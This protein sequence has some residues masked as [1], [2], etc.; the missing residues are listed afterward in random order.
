MKHT[1]TKFV[2]TVM[3]AVAMLP[4][5]ASAQTG[6]VTVADGT[7]SCSHLP[8]YGYWTDAAQHNQFIY[9]A[10]MLG[11]LISHN[12]I[13][14]TFYLSS[15][16]SSV[17]NNTITVR[18]AV[19]ADSVMG[20]SLIDL[21][22]LSGVTE[23]VSFTGNATGSTM[24][25]PFD[26]AFP[27]TGGN[28]L[29]D[30]QTTAA[31][32][33]SATFSGIT[34]TGA[35]IYSYSSTI[36]TTDELPKCTFGWT[37]GALCNAPS[38]LTASAPTTSS[39]TITWNSTGATEYA[40]TLNDSTSFTVSDTTYT[41][42]ELASNTVYNYSVRAIC[43]M[44]TS[45]A[46]FG[47]TRTSCGDFNAPYVNGFEDDPTYTT[48]NCW[49]VLFGEYYSYYS[50]YYPY[51]Y[52]WN[53][54]EGNQSLYFYSYQTDNY[55]VL[56]KIRLAANEMDVVFWAYY[57]SY[58]GGDLEAGVMTNP[59]DTSTF[60]PMLTVSAPSPQGVWNEYE[61][62]TDQLPGMTA[63]DTVYVAFRIKANNYSSYYYIDDLSV[64]QLTDCRRPMVDTLMAVSEDSIRF[65]W[66]NGGS[67]AQTYEVV[68]STVNDVNSA[69][70]IHLTD[71]TDTSLW[72]EGLQGNKRYYFWIRT[73]CEDTTGWRVCGYCNTPCAAEMP[74]PFVEDFESTDPS[75]SPL[76][77]STPIVYNDYSTIYPMV[78]DNGAYGNHLLFAGGDSYYGT[79]GYNMAVSPAIPLPANEIAISFVAT[80]YDNNEYGNYMAAGVMTDP[81]DTNTFIPM[82][83]VVGTG[84][85]DWVEYEFNTA[86]ITSIEADDT[87]YLAFYY[88]GNSNYSCY[89][90]IDNVTISQLSDCTRPAAAFDATDIT[91][92]GATLA[93]NSA[94][95]SS[96]EVAYSSVNDI[97]SDSVQTVTASDTTV[98]LTGLTAQTTYYAWVRTNCGGS[99]SDWR[100]F[101][102]F[103]T[104]C[105]EGG[106][107]LTINMTDG[108]GDGWNGSI[109]KFYQYDTVQIAS[110]TIDNGATGTASVM[111]CDES[112]ITMKMEVGFFVSEVGF[113]VTNTNHVV[114]YVVESGDLS[115]YSSGDIITLDTLTN[116]CGGCPSAT[117]IVLDSSDLT[118]I[119]ISWSG[120]AESYHLY[121]D[122]VYVGSTTDTSYTFTG[123][124]VAKAYTVGVTGI[125]ADGDSAMIATARFNTEC[126]P[127]YNVPWTADF[128]N[129]D[130]DLVPLCWNR[131]Y[132]YYSYSRY[133]YCSSYYT[134]T[135][136]LPALYFYTSGVN[137]K[138]LM[139]TPK[140]NCPANQLRITFDG[141][142]YGGSSYAP[143]EVGIM[144]DPNNDSTFVCIDTLT[145]YGN[146]YTY[147]I[148]S[149]MLTITDS[150]HVAFRM[151]DNATATYGYG[152]IANLRVEDAGTCRRALDLTTTYNEEEDNYTVSWV[153]TVAS[154][155]E[156]NYRLAGAAT[157]QTVMVTGSTSYT[158][159]GLNTSSTYEVSVRALCPSGDTSVAN[160]TTFK[161]RCDIIPLPYFT[162][163]NNDVATSYSNEGT[164]PNCWDYIYTGTSM[165]YAPKVT[166]GT[167]A[168][169]TWGDTTNFIWMVAGE[170][171]SYGNDVYVALPPM[172]DPINYL[173]M[174]FDYAFENTT[175]GSNLTVG[176]ATSDQF[177][178]TFVAVKTI[179]PADQNTLA[180]DTVVFDSVPDNATRIVF[181]WNYTTSWYSVAID[182]VNVTSSYVGCQAP[183]VTSNAATDNSITV[184]FTADSV[185]EV[186]ITDGVWNSETTGTV[187]SG[188]SYTFTGLTYNTAY[189]IGL[190][191]I[192]AEGVVSDWTLATVTT[193]DVPCMEPTA[194]AISNIDYHTATATWTA[195][196]EEANWEVNIF[197]TNINESYTT[198]S[199][200]YAFSNL[201]TGTQYSVSVRAL[202]GSDANIEGPWSDTVV[203][204]TDA[205][206]PVTGV[207][208]SNL[209]ATT[210][211]VSWTASSNS[212]SYRVEYGFRGMSQ[213]EGTSVTVNATS[214]TITGL[215]PE[216]EYDVYVQA[217][218]EGGE[219]SVWSDVSSFT[220]TAASG[221]IYTISAVPADPTMGSV[222]GGG[223]YEE[224]TQVTLTAVPNEG[225]HFVRWQDGNTDNPRVVTVTGNATYVATF[226]ANAGIEDI[227][228][229]GYVS[230]YPNPASSTVTV[231][232][233]GN[234]SEVVVTIVD[235]NGREV[236]RE[237]TSGSVLT[238]DIS[239][240][241]QG[242]Y[243]VRLTG[244]RVNA[245]R[246]LIVK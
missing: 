53:S 244:E 233:E 173:T 97:N 114:V 169:F 188:N 41:F 185:V 57:S 99:V 19:V 227:N 209:T 12:I 17:W 139:V 212:S 113:T 181:R 199:P 38:G 81:T 195:G 79:T 159:N 157:W 238:M 96:Y 23:V 154:E 115:G 32:Y 61:F 182:N 183:V 118:S 24:E 153:N 158:L 112:P 44:D 106:C 186:A 68:Y 142:F 204:T 245:I 95:G 149:D 132:S 126:Y 14:M 40:I 135:G 194:L 80:V 65:V 156:F 51:V 111:V 16:A 225:Y 128:T 9:P 150:V 203:F 90:R 92:S 155:F 201:T 83:E 140:L 63:D 55:V 35:G 174:S 131:L 122:S 33:S 162:D 210:A 221:N 226:E 198:T 164:M 100:A 166:L 240:L 179:A 180:T 200:T 39:F 67:D 213:G 176:Y 110:M 239:S 108:Y 50:T 28:L 228:G 2:A 93:W 224:N 46:K 86:A 242:A 141:Y 223:S 29:I 88:W 3:L 66:N 177:D 202:C 85:T 243:F 102:P 236:K 22:T 130:N 220:T 171:N 129:Y 161:T 75:I 137:A 94:D 218:C 196:G 84:S 76:C 219:N 170:P 160:T 37:D 5:M 105:A 230:L 232:V 192:C 187:V 20:S 117:D 101:N 205:C 147:D 8:V 62:Y 125:C 52:G 207:T 58:G 87:L 43:G 45:A 143:L 184:N 1:I 70:A 89:A 217:V 152:Y 103:T 25:I 145:G 11:D 56:P 215:Q 216:T 189:T 104:L 72:I 165:S 136:N 74:I 15:P 59:L 191:T 144:T 7:A 148:F 231:S 119:S 127:S 146:W 4:G 64:T 206:Q 120:S 124:T 193:E 30:V 21:A 211:Q 49:N 175:N 26:V 82:V 234:E 134:S 151:Y 54:H 109:L 133:P 6:D 69:S 214:Y 246:K 190:R 237:R 235:M 107:S 241:S 91:N 116:F 178:S 73:I 48:P 98:T 47:S 18:L 31:T 60:I 197:N 71:I 77:W 27:Y 167:G 36:S 138:N 172:A 229:A 222:Q 208:V 78:S 168:Y 13:R 42:N 121:L 10:S 163:F 34:R 123:L